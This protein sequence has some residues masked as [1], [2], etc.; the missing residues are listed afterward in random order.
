MTVNV[1]APATI[2]TDI[3]GGR[4]TDDR[5]PDFLAQLPVGRLG[6]TRDVAALVE[7]LLGADAGYITGATYNINGVSALAE[8]PASPASPFPVHTERPSSSPLRRAHA[9]RAEDWPIAAAMLQFAPHA[10][11]GTPWR[12]WTRGVAPPPP[13][14][15]GRGFTHLELSTAWLPLGD[16]DRSRLERLREPWPTPGS[17]C[18]ASASSGAASSTP[19]TARSTSPS[20]TG[21]STRQPPSARTS[22][23]SGSTTP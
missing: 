2:D 8:S 21:P 14:R 3:M 13:A 19:N 16:L 9:P 17:R 6:T 12:S 4:I 18:P 5:K 20:R 11:D 15:R 1:V 10:A 23:A 7:F 22:S